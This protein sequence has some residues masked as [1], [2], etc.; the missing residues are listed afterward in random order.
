VRTLKELGR[1]YLTITKDAT[2]SGIASKHCIAAGRF[3]ALAQPSMLHVIAPS[4]WP[5]SLNQE[6]GSSGTALSATGLLQLVRL[7]A[8]RELLVESHK[9]AAVKLLRQIPSIGPIRSALLVALLQTP[10]RFRPSANY[11][12]QWFRRRDSRQR[13]V[14]LRAR[15][16]AT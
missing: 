5:R 12:L 13:R 6:F 9:H 2:A 14:P 15:Q 11:G 1:S 8:R 16:T 3:P 10:H 4:G 7:E